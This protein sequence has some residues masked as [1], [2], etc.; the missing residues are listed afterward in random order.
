MR[1]QWTARWNND[2]PRAREMCRA[3][4]P[5]S[6]LHTAQVASIE[7]EHHPGMEYMVVSVQDEN[8]VDLVTHFV[9]CF[10]FIDRGRAAGEPGTLADT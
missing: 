8:S 3:Q 6:P 5:Q 2:L 9:D 1:A 4:D 10:D 7:Q